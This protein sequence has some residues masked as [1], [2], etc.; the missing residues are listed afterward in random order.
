LYAFPA[1]KTNGAYDSF[2]WNGVDTCFIFQI[3]IAE[4]HSI[5]NHCVKKFLEWIEV[6]NI[7]KL[8]VKFVFVVPSKMIDKWNR[9]QAFVKS[10]GSVYKNKGC[11]VSITQY[12]VSLDL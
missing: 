1:S 6:F 2:L 3:T 8:D 11:E 4:K 10:G 9:P 5:L 12:V 7:S